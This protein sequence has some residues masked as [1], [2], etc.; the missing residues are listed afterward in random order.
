MGYYILLHYSRSYNLFDQADEIWNSVL[1]SSHELQENVVDIYICILLKQRKF[2]EAHDI[3]TAYSD[4][5]T[6][7]MYGDIFGTLIQMGELELAREYFI[8]ARVNNFFNYA[9]EDESIEYNFILEG[10]W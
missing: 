4:L 1:E 9:S 10:P 2:K 5:K 7:H 3:F 8:D 6:N